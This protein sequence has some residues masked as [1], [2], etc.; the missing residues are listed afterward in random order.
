MRDPTDTTAH[1]H[2]RHRI[3]SFQYFSKEASVGPAFHPGTRLQV[4]PVL[5]NRADHAAPSEGSDWFR[6]SAMLLRLHP[7]VLKLPGRD[8]YTE[9]HGHTGTQAH[10]RRPVCN[11]CGPY[12]RL[13]E[14]FKALPGKGGHPPPAPRRPG[15]RS[16]SISS[17]HV[18][19]VSVHAGQCSRGDCG[20]H[21]TLPPER[22]GT[23]VLMNTET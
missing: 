15:L 4:F 16:P 19:N 18:V 17:T 23:T 11:L 3:T 5:R 1:K 14:G 13:L 9:T 8:T 22:K 12:V 7:N 20:G 6:S 10:R 2:S 21:R